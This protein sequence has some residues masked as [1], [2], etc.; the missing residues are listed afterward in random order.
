MLRVPGQSQPQ[1]PPLTIAIVRALM[2][3]TAPD[4]LCHVLR[5]LVD[6]H[7]AD[8]G[9]GRGWQVDPQL[10]RA[11]LGQLAEQLV[12]GRGILEEKEEE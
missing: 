3:G 1:S 7:G 8:A 11:G 2:V 12:E 5:L 10:H 9:T 4:N 6:G